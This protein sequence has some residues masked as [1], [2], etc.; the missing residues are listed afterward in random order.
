LMFLVLMVDAPRSPAASH[1]GP[2]INVFYVDGERS[3]ISFSTRQRAHRQYFLALWCA[4][5]DLQ[6]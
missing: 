4:P 2:A 3:L 1:R 6:H 5:S